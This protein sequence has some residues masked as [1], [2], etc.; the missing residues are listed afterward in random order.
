MGGT[1]SIFRRV[2]LRA[3]IA[4]FLSSFAMLGVWWLTA[5]LHILI[6]IPVGVLVYGV[7]LYWLGGIDK[8]VVQVLRAAISRRVGSTSD[9][10]HD[11]ESPRD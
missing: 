1:L 9:A 8:G 6:R 7:V 10:L 2:P 5:S 11:G 3:L 4:P